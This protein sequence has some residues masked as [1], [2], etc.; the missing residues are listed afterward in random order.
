MAFLWKDLAYKIEYVILRQKGFMRLTPV[1]PLHLQSQ[2]QSF[3]RDLSIHTERAWL[4]NKYQH[5]WWTKWDY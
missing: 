5:D 4:I 1:L 2:L 3:H